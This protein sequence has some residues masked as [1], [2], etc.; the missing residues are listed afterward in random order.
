MKGIARQPEEAGPGVSETTVTETTKQG[1]EACVPREW[2]WVEASVWTERML[3]A[4]GN[5]VKG[6]KWFSLMDKVYSRRNLEAAWRRVARN[7]GA[8]GVDR[9][10][11]G[12]F[13]A[14]AGRYLDELERVLRQGEYRPQALRR[15]YIPKGGGRRRPLGLPVVKDRI[16]Q[17]ALKQVLEPI[18]ENEFLDCSYGFRP[19]RSGKDALREVDR[20]LK[21]GHTWVVDA[22]IVDCFGSIPH[23]LLMGRVKE[24]VSDGRVLAL[25][26]HYLR[27]DVLE[28]MKR[29]TPTR[30][31]PQGAVI[32]PLLANIYLHQLDKVLVEGGYRVVRYADDFV[33][34]CR[35]R[36]AAER[37]LEVVQAWTRA[38][39]LAL[40]PDKTHI[41]DCRVAG[42]GFE[43]L[44]YRF[45]AGRRYVRKGS[46]KAVRDKIRH[47]TPRTSGRSLSWIIDELNPILRGWFGYFQ[48]AHPGTFKHLDGFVRRRLRAILR[49]RLKRPG[50]GHT[51]EDHRRW[52][53][54]Y[55]AAQGL[56]TTYEAYVLACRSR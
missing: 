27:Q 21:A 14:D 19:G 22:D 26:E 46:W 1:S 35:S 11:I 41:G 30:G 17:A 33:I 49:R 16:V 42:Q 34:L 18:F 5:G 37:A 54:A 25:L 3:A 51:R 9:V 55:F 2:G 28:G 43:F 20:L 10:S 47:K 29:W 23:G 56:F 32:S 6:G 36:K 12:R 4:L 44:G 45:E 13:K 7:R 40:H 24:H 52:S 15:V 8:A 39:G 31:T 38:N 48:H 53:N 50:Q